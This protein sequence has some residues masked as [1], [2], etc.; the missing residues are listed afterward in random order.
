[1]LL[2]L[3]E[4]NR[5]YAQGAFEISLGDWTYKYLLK[6]SEFPSGESKFAWD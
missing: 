6:F 5:T 1:M 4:I 3:Q 2:F